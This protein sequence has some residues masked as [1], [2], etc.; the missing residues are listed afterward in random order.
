MTD[1]PPPGPSVPARLGVTADVD[2]GEL[3]LALVPRPEHLHHGRVRA[4]VHVFLVDLLAGLRINVGNDA[5]TL[6][7]DLSLRASAVPAPARI[8]ARAWAAR[9]GRRNGTWVIDITGDDGVVATGA[10]SFITLERR[11]GDADKPDTSPDA[12]IA[13]FSG[14]RP[15]LTAPLREEAGIETIDPST[16]IVEVDVTHDVLNTNG[17]MQGAMVA[18]VAEAAAEDLVESR[19]GVRAVVTD[20]DVRYLNRVERGRVQSSCRLLG[21]GP[22]ATV[23]VLLRDLDRDR[24]TTLAYA[25][26]TVL[27]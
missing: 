20:L 9:Q 17:T 24:L 13:R 10:A 6:T 22:E 7:S 26:A 18:L 8:E 14:D 2:A 23:E 19:F 16:G 5:W 1:L 11:A 27:D 25:R 12:A 4:S 21:D 3:V 15:P